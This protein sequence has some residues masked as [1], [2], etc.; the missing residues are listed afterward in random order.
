M[1]SKKNR[2]PNVFEVGVVYQSLIF[3]VKTKNSDHVSN[4]YGCAA[5]QK[6]VDPHFEFQTTIDRVFHTFHWCFSVNHSLSHFAKL[7]KKKTYKSVNQLMISG[8]HYIMPAFC[9]PNSALPCVFFGFGCATPKRMED[10]S[11]LLRPPFL[12]LFS[13][14]MAVVLGSCCSN[15]V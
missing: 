3:N 14:Q 12:Q 4:S 10:V 2:I 8:E 13:V 5:I 9:S 11:K 1:W 6:I 7:S 15:E